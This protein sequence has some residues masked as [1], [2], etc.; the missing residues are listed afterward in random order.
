MAVVGLPSSTRVRVAADSP[1]PPVIP[2]SPEE[3]VRLV[4]L[5]P[6]VGAWLR[7]GRRKS[8]ALECQIRTSARP[9]RHRRTFDGDVV[10][11]GGELPVGWILERDRPIRC[12]EGA[13][14]AGAVTVRL[15][16]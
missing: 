2:R 8:A 6:D 14:V 11:I 16:N 1:H 12:S 3:P 10:L 9:P 13:P 4:E 5:L 7:V 15:R